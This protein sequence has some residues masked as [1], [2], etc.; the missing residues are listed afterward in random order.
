MR[1]FTLGWLARLIAL[2]LLIAWIGSTFWHS[3]RRLPPG[4]HIAGS[5]ESL[6]AEQIKFL[7][8][9]STADA[10]GA[11]LNERQIDAELSGMIARAREIV[12][13]DA[14]LFGDLPAA[15]PRAS[16]LRIAPTIAAALSDALLK[17]KQDQPALQVLML[18]DPASIDLSVAPGPIERLRSGGID[19][20]S[21]ATGR[22]RAPD[23]PFVAFWQLCCGW[24]S[25][26]RGAGSW[27]NP[28]G[29]G[30]AGVAMGLWGRTPPYQRSHRQLIVADDGSGTLEGMIFSRPL[31]AEAALHSA[32]ALRVSGAALD[33]TLE[34]EFA[35]A[36]FSGWSGGGAMQARAQRLIERQRQGPNN[37]PVAPGARARVVSESMIGES[38]VALIDATGRHDSI[39]VAALY[40]CERDLVRALLDAARRGVAVRVLLDPDKDGYGYDRSGLPNRVVAS[41]LVA[42]SDGAVRVRW[43]RTHG[44]QFSAGFVLIRGGAHSWLAVGTSDFSRRDLDDFNLAAAFIAELPPT[45]GAA[46][47]ALTWFDTLWFNRAAGGVEYT[48]DADVYADA[49]QLHYWQYRLLEAAGAAFD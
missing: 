25:H 33:A 22:L 40:L 45:A 8:D 24:W 34:S 5:W 37:A 30:S 4:L 47:E 23:A 18:I 28:I 49:S 46:L 31:N 2:T 29:V 6:A 15:G 9:L 26:G 12:V 1:G 10:T 42:N 11:P 16:R 17:A 27:P 35:V 21:V 48:S 44:E 14:G 19:V 41:E 13:L 39:D 36:Q 3:D 43:Y 32:T 38:L 7:R 20:V